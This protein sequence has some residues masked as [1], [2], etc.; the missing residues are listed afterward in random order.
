MKAVTQTKE[1]VKIIDEKGMG[2]LE[3]FAVEP[4]EAVLLEL[5]TEIFSDHWDK[6]QFGPLIQGAAWEI[7]AAGPPEKIGMLDGYLTVDFGNWHFHICIGEHKGTRYHPVDAELAAHRRTSRAEFYRLINSDG[8]PDSWGLR[9]LNGKDE[10]QITVFLPNP[11]LSAQMK[12]QEPDW[13]RLTLWDHLRRKYL[14]L[15]PEDR[16]RSGR[17]MIHG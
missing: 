4:S 14:G 11:F 15:E 16:D 9:L 1:P 12:F 17:R 3:I 7:Q 5:L 8:T 10:Q 6:V 13:S 2:R